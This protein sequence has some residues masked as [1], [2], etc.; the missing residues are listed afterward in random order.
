MPDQFCPEERLS[1]SIFKLAEPLNWLYHVF[2]FYHLFSICLDIES[3]SM[4]WAI[5]HT[6][7][8]QT[9]G[10]PVHIKSIFQHEAC[11]HLCLDTSSA[12]LGIWMQ[13][14]N[15]FHHSLKQRIPDT[16]WVEKIPLISPLYHLP[17]ILKLWPLVLFTSAKRKRF[18]Q[19]TYLYPS[20]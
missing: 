5:W 17:L 3:Y 15:C 4:K 10:H 9:S 12:C 1:F 19:S 7:I 18:L 14:A 6:M 16:L 2:L 20:S 11:G 13:S 8:T